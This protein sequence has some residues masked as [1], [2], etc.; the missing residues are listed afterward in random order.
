MPSNVSV[1][2]IARRRGFSLYRHEYWLYRETSCHEPVWCLARTVSLIGFCGRSNLLARELY[3][4]LASEPYISL[5]RMLPIRFFCLFSRLCF[6][7]LRAVFFVLSPYESFKPST[8]RHYGS[9][10][11][12]LYLA[13][14]RATALC[15]SCSLLFRFYRC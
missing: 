5:L 13:R 15:H 12:P 9:T 2:T 11:L 3:V 4:S 1:F 14:L 6:C 10:S 7:S 8:V